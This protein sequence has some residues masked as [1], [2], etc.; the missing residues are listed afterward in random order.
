MMT[1]D[2]PCGKGNMIDLSGY[3]NSTVGIIGVICWDDGDR[4]SWS[5][6]Y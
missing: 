5:I 6:A 1:V 2:G 3:Y 4:W